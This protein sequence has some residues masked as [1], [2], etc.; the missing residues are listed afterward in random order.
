MGEPSQGPIRVCSYV[1][2]K[3]KG[4]IRLKF[5]SVEHKNFALQLVNSSNFP[6]QALEFVLGFK[7][8]VILAGLEGA[9]EV[10]KNPGPP[11]ET[12]KTPEP[13]TTTT[14]S[15]VPVTDKRKGK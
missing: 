10:A 8:A 3:L 2:L 6:G 4:V 11:A 12:P 1:N 7:Q 9:G 13:E 15:G 5:N 14:P